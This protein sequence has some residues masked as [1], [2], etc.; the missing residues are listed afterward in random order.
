MFLI[1]EVPDGA[2]YT[3]R[4]DFLYADDTGL[5]CLLNEIQVVDPR[6][7]LKDLASYSPRKEIRS[8]FEIKDFQESKRSAEALCSMSL[9]RIESEFH[10]SEKRWEIYLK[11]LEKWI[12]HFRE[13]LPEQKIRVY[14]GD[15]VWDVLHT[16]GI[17]KAEDVDFVRM[18]NSSKQSSIGM[19]WRNLAFDDCRYPYVYVE[20]LDE[21]YAYRGNKF[22]P[23]PRIEAHLRYLKSRFEPTSANF[24][25]ALTF[26]F[27]EDSLFSDEKTD[28][29]PF[30]RW[31]DISIDDPVF[32]HRLCNFCR[33]NA[34]TLIRSLERL[35][36][37][38]TRVLCRYLTLSDT[39][40]FYHPRRHIWTNFR[41]ITPSLD[42][43]FLD[44]RWLFYLT[45]LV[46]VKWWIP[47]EKMFIFDRIYK[48]YGEQTM[49][50][51]LYKQLVAEGN[52]LE[53]ED[54]DDDRGDP[55]PF[56]SLENLSEFANSK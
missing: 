29:I 33:A 52:Y 11:G 51:R 34:S 3:N 39:Q 55:F 21:R 5:D 45:K 37:D 7:E 38:M 23:V 24:A 22:Q 41:E 14:V 40:I 54:E 43:R 28:E 30:F 13:N 53:I 16:E 27:D 15:D 4:S 50:I 12:V 6:W 2:I 9:F 32:I 46:E 35:P 8:F 42:F 10:Q 19:L 18:A 44:E 47:P 31:E 1:P 20:D 17:L 48:R 26:I 25:S 49:L 36:F 56:D